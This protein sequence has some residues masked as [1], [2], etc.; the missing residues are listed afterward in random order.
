MPVRIVV[1]FLL[2]RLPRRVFQQPQQDLV[3]DRF[4][5]PVIHGPLDD[6]KRLAQTVVDPV[7]SGAP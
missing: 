5:N 3:P 6:E 2:T 7:V 4:Q 1:R